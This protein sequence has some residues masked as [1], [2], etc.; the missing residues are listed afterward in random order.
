MSKHHTKKRIKNKHQHHEDMLRQKITEELFAEAS[1]QMTRYVNRIDYLVGANNE[2]ASILKVTEDSV[3]LLTDKIRKLEKN[4]EG[5]VPIPN[6][7]ADCILLEN[8][9]EGFENF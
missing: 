5:C 8:T 4:Q 6:V 1:E 2:L 9:E 3:I 7:A